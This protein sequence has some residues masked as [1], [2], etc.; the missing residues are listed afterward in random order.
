MGLMD[1]LLA[2]ILAAQYGRDVRQSIH[3]AIGECYD[4]VSTAKTLATNAT[5]SANTAATLANEKATLANEKATLANEKATLANTKAGLAQS[6][7]DAANDVVGWAEAATTAAENMAALANDILLEKHLINP[8]GPYQVGDTYKILD[9]VS[10]DGTSYLYINP[11]EAS[12]IPLNDTGRWMVFAA[13][14]DGSGADGLSVIDGK[15][16]LTA[17]G[18]IISNGVTMPAGGGGTGGGSTAINLVNLMQGTILNVAKGAP[19]VVSFNYTSTDDPSKGTARIYVDEVVKATVP[20]NQGSNDLDV[21]AYLKE[22]GNAVRIYCYDMFSNSKSITYTINAIDLK[23]TSTFDDS[24]AY[25]GNISL[26]YIPYGAT[27]KVIHFKIDGAEVATSNVSTTGKQVT[28]ILPVMT[29]GAH[30]LE[31]YSTAVIEGETIT[32]PILHYDVAA[33]VSG[34]TQ[35]I[36]TSSFIPVGVLQGQ[37]IEIPFLVYDP[38]F[39]TVE[40]ELTISKDGVDYKT[41][42]IT[43]DRTKQFWNTRDYPDGQ[44]SFTI[45][46]GGVSK[47]HVISI[48]TSQLSVS[49]VTD[50]LLLH[51]DS[52]GRSNNESNPE[53]WENSGIITTFQ[54]F[55]W[56]DNGWVPDEQGDVTLR[57]S[58]KAKIEIGIKPFFGEAKI[59]GKTIELEYAIRNVNNREAVAMSCVSNG[60]GL[61]VTADQAM[62][63][64]EQSRI[65]A[66]YKDETKNRISFVVG[67]SADDRLL[68]TY[69]NGVISGVVQYPASDNFEQTPAINITAGSDLCTIDLYRIRIYDAA[70]TTDQ[71]RDNFV[72][73]TADVMLR[74]SRFADNNSLYDEFGRLSFSKIK[75]IIPTMVI[76]GSLPVSKGDKKSI[77]VEYTDPRNPSLNFD[78]TGTIDVQGTSS[79]FYVRKNW[80]IKFKQIHQHAPDRL[81]SNVFCMKADYAEATGTHNTQNANYVEELYPSK[82]PPQQLYEGV[83]TTIYGFPC[84]IYHR[85]NTNDVPSFHGKYNFNYDKGSLSVFGF[86]SEFPN[87]ECWEF[88]NNTS[89]NCLFKGVI[90]E[91]MT[92]NDKGEAMYVWQNNFEGRQPDGYTDISR[93]KIMHSWVV[94]TAR[95]LATDELLSAPYVDIDNVTHTH[96]TADYRLAK[97]KT[98]FND[99][100]KM[101]FSLLY[102]VY[103]LTMLM[104]DQR[105]KNMF[106]TT[107]DGVKW[108]PWFYD[109]DTCLG[110]NNEGQLVFD[111]YHED[112]DYLEGAEIFN[113]QSS[114]LWNNFKDAFPVEIRQFYQSLRGSKK[115]SYDNIIEHFI[116]NGSDKW[117]ESIYNE[118]AEFKY[119]SPLRDNNDASNL[120]QV[121][122]TG[123]EHLKYFVSNRLKYLD[124]KWYAPEY[125]ED[126]I[127]LRVYTPAIGTWFGV[128]PN[129]NITLTPFSNM[130]GGVRY[131]ANATIISH[132]IDR[133]IPHTFIAPV[134]VYNDTETSIYGASQISSLGDL[135]PL[136]C[137][138][139]NVSKATRLKELIVGSPDPAYINNNLTV[140]SVGTNKLL[141]KIDV[142]GCVNLEAPL[143]LSGCPSIE[144]IQAERTKITGVE[145]S[146][147]GYVKILRMPNTVTN[148]T[149]LNQNSIEDFYCAGYNALTTLR[150]E[151]S[152]GVSVGEILQNA[153]NLVRLRLLEVDLTLPDES[154]LTR[155]AALGGLDEKNN[156]IPQS[157]LTG[158]IR[159]NATGYQYQVE[160][161]QIIW[162][163]LTVEFNE[164]ISTHTVTFRDWNDAVLKIE[165]VIQGSNAIPPVNPTRDRVGNTAYIFNGWS[166][167]YINVQS[168][169]DVYATYTAV[170]C[171]DV[172]FKNW[173]GA[174]LKIESVMA[175]DDATPPIATRPDSVDYYRYTFSS[176]DKSYTN[177]RGP[178]EIFA[179]FTATLIPLATA[180]FY[181]YNGT[182]MNSHT[183]ER[184]V[185]TAVYPANN[186]N[187]P[188]KPNGSGEDWKFHQWV[189]NPETTVVLED[190]VFTA[191]FKDWNNPSDVATI[192]NIP[193]FLFYADKI[194]AYTSL[195]AGVVNIGVQAFSNCGKLA[196]TSLPVALISIGEYA[197]ENCINLALTFLP[198]GLIS[199]GKSAFENCSKLA[200]LSIS[201]GVTIF[202]ECTFYNCPLV[203]LTSLPTGTTQIGENAFYKCTNLSLTSLPDGITSISKY[204]FTD[205]PNLTLT[206]LPEG[207][208]SIDR[209]AFQGCTKL[210]LTSLPN[211]ITRIG[212][213]A[214]FNCQ[215]LVLTELPPGLLFIGESAFMNCTGLVSITI[216]VGVSILNNYTFRYCSNLQTF[217]APGIEII[218]GANAA[219]GDNSKLE[220]VILGSIGH[221]VT[222]INYTA[223]HRDTQL[224]LTITIYVTPGAQPLSGSPWGATNATI[225]YRS[226]V[227]GSVL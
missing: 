169:F 195:P 214:F 62:F 205:C 177:V 162:P 75:D 80:K 222:S 91:S 135:A 110:I 197:F 17:G 227:D 147:T 172:T 211:G 18:V 203:A 199:I 109:N 111:Y 194:I 105:A 53:V 196:L 65:A 136:Y 137:G 5:N 52:G 108:E 189:P 24:M 31:I 46:Y 106:L 90:D 70:L 26:K 130:Y 163:L 34:E 100:F 32:S 122:G 180:R 57:L 35:P 76:T 168:S 47:T 25:S 103:T 187:V 190:T 83:R 129:A 56:V 202:E 186:S 120:Y 14:G 153:P 123:E 19:M 150:V 101:D 127:Y 217:I 192:T 23:I 154:I 210:A 44:V 170:P 161:Y 74:S 27:D 77:R 140:L 6:A 98:E 213:G 198:A 167:I 43:V 131:K 94:S 188:Q 144:E 160:A 117:T 118:D 67:T 181:N 11:Q 29:H 121:R 82:T 58:G 224:G 204:S 173:D 223:F 157:V 126:N 115:L 40:A 21:T 134:E 151:N 36:I 79:Q 84:V 225:V 68:S 78:D 93:F 60:I 99:H 89:E 179:E 38:I 141:T 142:R 145:L 207:I 48:E 20:L 33:I 96:D 92:V 66:Q 69:L 209:Y 119:V 206:S 8:K 164:V 219:L 174:V 50:G 138:Q 216:P 218:V 22:G 1:Q 4:D 220:T 148:I 201:E 139:I 9:L 10:K 39:T 95:E 114:T 73:D 132:R 156:N 191:E 81:P 59:S 155:L 42:T 152:L 41:K 200:L 175:G 3:D 28:Q 158:T 143:A 71:I 107:W 193:D 104:T 112:I 113:G 7:A 124:G 54:D 221:P 86:T 63:L 128:E 133:N 149:V 165:D 125:A 2:Q 64:S 116:T 182:Y 183:L 85:E 208:T 72:A 178:M 15:L 159:I 185:T 45:S 51:L 16:Y 88:A 102:Y 184:G 215:N 226:T 97:F 166:P 49:S 13:K 61:E 176:W 212:A 30:T 87:A 37:L 146:E 55:N 171:Y 12:G